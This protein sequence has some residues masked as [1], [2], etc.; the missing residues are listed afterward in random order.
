MYGSRL[1]AAGAPAAFLADDH[2]AE[3]LRRHGVSVNGEVL[4]LTV[5]TWENPPPEPP[6]FIMVAVKHQHLPEVC[7]RIGSITAEYT[8]ILSVMN[9]IDSEE[10]LKRAAGAGGGGV[11]LPAMVAGMD[12]VRRNDGRGGAEV[13]YTQLGKVFFGGAA[14]PVESMRA[15]LEG[16]GIPCVVSQDIHR[17]IWNKFMLNVG[18]N[19][20]SA[21]LRAPYRHFHHEGPGRTLMRMAMQEVLAVAGK[22]GINLTEDDLER[23]FSV[24]ETLSPDGK[25]SM[26]Q[27]VEA[28]RKTEVE[29]F[30]GRMVEMGAELQVPT[31]VNTVLLH[32]IRGMEEVF[33]AQSPGVTA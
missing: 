10:D 21:V 31:P 30:A 19:Q 9:G 1:A 33:V 7:R 6:R 13:R 15:F 14:A 3:Q 29:M 28:Q 20:W 32:T 24:V 25:T 5:Y 11:V 17:E 18:I 2:R 16:S 12:A 8:T 4:R 22:R 23:W 26:L 27:D